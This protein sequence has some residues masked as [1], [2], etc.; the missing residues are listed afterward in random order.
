MM[1]LVFLALLLVSPVRADVVGYYRFP[2]IHGDTVVFAAEGDLWR[3]PITGGSAMRLTTHDGNE[4]FP[5][6][7]PDGRWLAFSGEYG[8]N[9]DVYVMPAT[10]GEPQRLTFHPGRDEV[11]AWRPSGRSIVF[12]SRRSSGQRAERRLFEVPVTGGYPHII[13]V[14]LASL[15]SFSPDGRYIAF[16]RLSREF[17]TWKRYR[18][19][20]AQDIWIGDLE[21]HS[22]TRLTDFDGTD[23]FPMWFD[24]RVY[25]LSD[26][27]GRLNIH[28]IGPDGSDAAQHTFHSEYDARWPDMHDGRIVYMYAGDLRLLDVRTGVDERIDITLPTDRVHRRLRFEDATETPVVYALNEDGSRLAVSSRGEMWTLPV[29]GGRTIA[30]TESSGVR[31]RSP[32]FSPDGERIACITDETGEQE[33]AIF[34][35][36]G[37]EPHRILTHENK[38]WTFD[39]IWSPDGSMI[40]YSD[41][42]FTLRIVDVE[43]GETTVI[44]TDAGWEIEQY[45]FS[46]DSRYLAYT[47][48]YKAWSM[49]KSIFIYDIAMGESHAITTRYTGDSD[50][51]WDPA[52]EYLYF[53][54]SRSYN[55]ILCDL[56]FEHIVTRSI[57]PCVVI[58]RADGLSPLLPDEVRERDDRASNEYVE[59]EFE[60]DGDEIPEVVIDFDGIERRV[61][62]LPVEPGNYRTLS[63]VD[64]RIFYGS[65]PIEGMLDE[66]WG[67]EDIEPRTTL[68]VYDF[69]E[70][71]ETVFLDMIRD[72]TISGD[73]STIAYRIGDEIEIASTDASPDEPDETIDPTQ[74][75]VAVNPQQEWSQI[76]HEAWRLERDF[77]WAPNMAGLDWKHVR[78]QYA[79]LLPRISTRS[80][81][82]DLVG[83]VIG[84]LGTSHTYIWGGDTEDADSIGV[85]LLGADLE[86]APDAD[87]YRF[88]RILQPEVWETDTP[89]P[90]TVSH[91]RVSDGDY[92]FAING[93]ALSAVDNVYERLADLAGAQVLL[94]IGSMP[95]RSDARDIQIEAL[96]SERQLRYRDWCRQRREW[97][98]ARSDGK[99]GY[100]H[101]PDMDSDGLIAFVKGYYPQ[102]NKDGL[103]IDVRYNGGGF[104]SGMII[105]RLARTLWAS[106]HV[107]RGQG[108]TYPER[109]HRG[110]KAVLINYFAGSDGDIFPESF[111]IRKLGPVIGTRTW[112]GVCG[113][114]ADK[115]FIDGG[116]CSQ[117]EFA[118]WEPVRGWGLENTGVVPDVEVDILPADSAAGRDPQ[119]DRAIDEL[120]RRIEEDPI[121]PMD[122]PAFPKR[123][124]PVHRPVDR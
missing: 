95:D 40:A 39:P 114:R 18:G 22:F 27:D 48:P 52:G 24:G 76:F 75:R 10:G 90:L 57:V 104:V 55:P 119:L 81:L 113:M 122:R 91:T 102:I 44:D 54:S 61:V 65:R 105:E 60:M 97:V 98:D 77:Y 58:L 70:R 88:T 4:A 43:S 80:E 66:V 107:R 74:L 49:D 89:A 14:G 47:V 33:I 34:G 93:H 1:R 87:A 3:V 69:A 71:E 117:P 116:M 123:S 73:G 67:E 32:V 11:V 41:L 106:D 103:I 109:V 46:P 37:H 101:L 5:K 86:P 124:L 115:A 82:N 38:G 25:F 72:Y 21:Q 29:A 111:K 78:D 110:H 96:V 15:A 8:G 94:T 16:N 99:I 50:P 121:E 12:R 63:A 83:Q 92:L 85:G 7:S 28:S 17:N 36:A 6:F 100:I 68:H 62:E 112:G 9:V 45:S 84:E 26:R 51:V 56:D 53:L 120:L 31:E 13:E 64:G 23:R 30:L 35:S 20:T 42:E 79:P 19:G 118:W 2:A 59:D 108:F